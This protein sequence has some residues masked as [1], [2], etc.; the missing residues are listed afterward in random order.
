MREDSEPSA[1]TVDCKTVIFFSNTSYVKCSNEWSGASVKMV[2]E[3]GERCYKIR[4][5][6]MH[7]SNLFKITR[8]SS[9]GKFPLV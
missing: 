6:A 1:L 4:L 2:R 9:N 3:N 8:S 5:S 7:V